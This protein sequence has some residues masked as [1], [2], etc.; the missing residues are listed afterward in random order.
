M[1][2]DFKPTG[3]NNGDETAVVTNEQPE[4]ALMNFDVSQE[5]QRLNQQLINSQEVDNIVSTINVYEPTTLVTFG[6]QAAEGISK[7]SDQVL[8]SVNMAQINDSGALLTSLATIM[9]QFDI[10]EIE[11]TANQGFFSKIFKNAQKQLDKILAKYH[12]MGDE[13]DKIYVQLKGYEHE[14]GVSNKKL[15]SLFD[16][17]VEYY[18]ELVKY[19]LAGEQGIAEID[20][21]LNKLKEEYT[22]TQDNMILMDI[23]N[24]EQAK[25]LL[26]QRVMD[27]KMAEHVAIQSLPMLKTME[28]SNL[29]LVRKINS[30]FIVTL[31]VFKQGITQAILLKR[32]R[33]Q[34]EAMQ[35]LD[36][37]T[38]EM[39]LKNASNTAE[40]AKMTAKLASG[41]SIKI[42]T[43]E[44]TW[45]TIMDGITETKQI[46]ENAKQKREEDS[47]RL[48]ELKAEYKSKM[49]IDTAN[50]A[51]RI[52]G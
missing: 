38:N 13:V 23:N 40:Q 41:S 36:E 25:T 4:T 49:A 9:D 20:Q 44:K 5:R 48:N 10:K 51:K 46:E 39:L 1:A 8:D 11:D 15:E 3:Q 45:Q 52:D 31:P 14:I 33:I 18:Q 43:L 35:A 26:E 21:H 22:K 50:D 47:A 6:A 29:N 17:N 16:A 2:I 42:E 24:I 30:A 27:L 34:A 19:I 37:R 32:Q 12:T 28:Y 7:C